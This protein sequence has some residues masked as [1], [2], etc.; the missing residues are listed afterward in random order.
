MR[1]NPEELASASLLHQTVK[2]MCSVLVS[3][4]SDA[5]AFACHSRISECLDSP[6][7]K[8]NPR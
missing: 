8:Q 2:V 7:R 6:Y 4:G 1:F 5:F 3:T